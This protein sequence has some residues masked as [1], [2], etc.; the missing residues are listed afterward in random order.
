MVTE[1]IELTLCGLE[2]PS[3]AEILNTDIGYVEATIWRYFVL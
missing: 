2:S 1:I 3:I